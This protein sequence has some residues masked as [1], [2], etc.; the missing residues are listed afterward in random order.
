MDA[1]KKSFFVVTGILVFDFGLFIS[2]RCEK[3]K[4]WQRLKQSALSLTG[5]VVCLR[6]GLL[7]QGS[8]LSR[9][10][11]PVVDA[12]VVDQAGEESSGSVIF[13]NTDV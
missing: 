1:S 12:D 4:G 3:R 2:D 6:V 11:R 7:C 5:R 9:L 10:H 8:N 13:P